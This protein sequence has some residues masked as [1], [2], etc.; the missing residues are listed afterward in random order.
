MDISYGVYF[1]HAMR[2]AYSCIQLRSLGLIY[3]YLFL[4]V[5]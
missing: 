5:L 4:K 3:Y 2:Y 1:L